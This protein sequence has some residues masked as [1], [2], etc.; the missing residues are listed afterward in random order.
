MSVIKK[1]TTAVAGSL[2]LVGM[3]AAPSLAADNS[4]VNDGLVNVTVGDV[5]LLQDVNV[6]VAADVTAQICG[7]EVGPVA[8]LG[9]AVDA[10]S[11]ES[12][13]C[14]DSDGPITITQN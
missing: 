1:A 3:A 4:T 12:V 8:V 10:T 14:T 13:V 2:F 11:I 7:V 9:E 5:T 6:A